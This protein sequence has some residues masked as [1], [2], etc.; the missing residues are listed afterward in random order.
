[1]CGRKPSLRRQKLPSFRDTY[2]PA[3]LRLTRRSFGLKQSHIARRGILEMAYEI[4]FL[5]VGDSNGDAICV[6]YGTAQTGYFI[7]V[8]DGGF[9][10]TAQTV[11]NHI[12][13][14]Y[15]AN[16]TINHMVLSHADTDR[17]WQVRTRFDRQH[18]D[19]DR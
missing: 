2:A 4:D 10:D 6:R 18:E 14:H 12:E 13:T 8:I 3:T 9:T 16:V 17:C 15:G 1:M 5:P 7:H 11:I 19:A